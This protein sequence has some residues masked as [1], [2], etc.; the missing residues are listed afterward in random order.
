MSDCSEAVALRASWG[1][2][3]ES[4]PHGEYAPRTAY[5]NT[6]AHGLLPARTTAALRETVTRMGDGRID[7]VAYF[8][9]VEAAR[10]AFAR[11]AG[12]A[13]ER[14]AVGSAVAVHTAV[15]AGSLPPGS[16][17]LYP[18]DEFSSLVTPFTQRAG[19]RLRAVELDG[20]AD[21]VGPGTT[22]VA[23]S[24]VQSLDGRVADLP[25]IRAAARRHGARTLVDTTQA[26]GWLPLSSGDFDF[27]VCAGFKWLLCPRGTSFLTVPEDGGGLVPLHAGW[28]A[29][30]DLSNSTYGPV[31]E[32]ARDARRF[33][34]PPGYLPWVAAARSLT[35][36]E[37]VGRAAIAAH[38]LGLARRFRAGLAELGMAAV[39]AD[40]PIVSAPGLGDAASAL[41]EAG[42]VVAARGGNLRA[43]F[44]LHNTEA[45]VD[46][47]LNALAD[48]GRQ[49]PLGT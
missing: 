25:A 42:I 44:H 12:V 9:E 15:I 26:T 11:V 24:A 13:P 27:T 4:L 23:V 8:G 33:D 41:H 16:E 19:V 36:V 7:S 32:L 46:R 48:A 28:I 5:L 6:A 17:V 38:D 35:L 2:A 10:A 43:S 49:A 31:G 21:A 22:L 18:H 30:A 39:P 14:V 29:A 20:L 40:S 34:E 47:A 1:V 37:E 3:V 45:D